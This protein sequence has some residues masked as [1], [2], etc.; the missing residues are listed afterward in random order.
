MQLL[1]SFLLLNNWNNNSNVNDLCIPID[2]TQEETLNV[3]IF[4]QSITHTRSVVQTAYLLYI[5]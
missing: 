3:L 5:Y 4:K 1:I 2:N